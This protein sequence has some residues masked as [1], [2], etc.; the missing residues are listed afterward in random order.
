MIKHSLLFLFIP[1]IL[2]L[3]ANCTS[4]TESGKGI[5][6][7]AD[8]E[9]IATVDNDYTFT[10]EAFFDTLITNYQSVPEAYRDTIAFL[11]FKAGEISVPNREP[12]TTGIFLNSLWNEENPKFE[13]GSNIYFLSYYY[14]PNISSIPYSYNIQSG[15]VTIEEYSEALCTG[16]FDLIAVDAIEDSIAI[17]GAFRALRAKE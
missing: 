13:I 14:P 3:A 9:F 1:L 17:T 4:P 15:N 5:E 12:I 16:T 11:T 6:D 8:G 7:I 10:G 2:F